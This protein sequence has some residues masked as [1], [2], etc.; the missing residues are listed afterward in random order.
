MQTLSLITMG[1]KIAANHDEAGSLV[2][3]KG[4]ILQPSALLACAK[5][6]YAQSGS[7]CSVL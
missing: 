2:H 4:S 6:Y 5:P 7:E 3:L 1:H